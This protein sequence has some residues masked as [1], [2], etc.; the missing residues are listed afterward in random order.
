MYG[1]RQALVEKKLEEKAT[2]ANNEIS[3]LDLVYNLAAF[4]HE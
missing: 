1:Q 4:A 2:Y 3:A